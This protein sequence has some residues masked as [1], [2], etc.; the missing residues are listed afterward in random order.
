ML[1]DNFIIIY[2]IHRILILLK[3]T[4][5]LKRFLIDIYFFKKIIFLKYIIGKSPRLEEYKHMEE[6]I[7]KDVGNIFKLNKI[8]KTKVVAIKGI[9]NPFSMKKENKAIKDRIILDIRNLYGHEE[10]YCKPI[11]VGNF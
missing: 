6:S 2:I 11:R 9:R 5:I 10:Y 1:Q 4:R 3:I 8:E 7:L